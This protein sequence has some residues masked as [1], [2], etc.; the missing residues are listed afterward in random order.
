MV[1][2]DHALWVLLCGKLVKLGEVRSG[3]VLESSAYCEVVEAEAMRLEE[4]LRLVGVEMTPY[5]DRGVQL[6]PI[7]H[8]YVVKSKHTSP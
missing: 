8:L 3:V 7:S 4:R 2:P 1:I 6:R 5:T